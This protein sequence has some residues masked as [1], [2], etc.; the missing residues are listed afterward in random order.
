MFPYIEFSQTGP[1]KFNEVHV[2][3]HKIMEYLAGSI[4]QCPLSWKKW[5]QGEGKTSQS[6]NC[7]YW[8]VHTKLNKYGDNVM[9]LYPGSV[10]PLNKYS[11]TNNNITLVSESSANLKE[12]SI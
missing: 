11:W 9:S 12:T 8:F 7:T 2:H 3:G 4:I 5:C 6:A 1:V 10:A